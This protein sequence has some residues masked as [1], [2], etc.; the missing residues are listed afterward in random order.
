MIPPVTRRRRSSGH[1][2]QNFHRSESGAIAL[3]MLAG[4][5]ILMLLAW[6]I[7]DSGK[8]SREKI[9]AQ[10][11]ADMAVS[12]QAAI[13]A[14]AINMMAY[15][16]VAKRSIFAIHTTY[17]SNFIAY[18]KWAGILYSVGDYLINWGV[19]EIGT[20][21][22]SAGDKWIHWWKDESRGDFKAFS[23]IDIAQAES[24]SSSEDFLITVGN[25]LQNIGNPNWATELGSTVTVSTLAAHAFPV[26]SSD[27]SGYSLRYHAQDIRAL[28]NYQRYLAGV[29]PWWGWS[30]QL[31]RGMRNGASATGTFPLPQDFDQ[32]LGSTLNQLLPGDA[33]GTGVIDTLPIRPADAA[34]FDGANT[35]NQPRMSMA[36]VIKEQLKSAD[37][38]DM[39]GDLIDGGTPDFENMSDSVM[40]VEHLVNILGAVLSSD[41]PELSYR[42]DD[43][44]GD[45]DSGITLDAAIKAVANA[46]V[47]KLV[48]MVFPLVVGVSTHRI[49]VDQGLGFTQKLF[50]QA[51][52]SA[53]ASPWVVLRYPNEA[54]WLLKTSNIVLSYDSRHALFG[55]ERK[56]HNIPSSEY[57]IG[58]PVSG[59]GGLLGSLGKSVYRSSGYWGIARA[60]VYFSADGEPNL[61]NPVWNSRLRPV[62]LDQEFAQ[63]DYTLAGVY[64]D[65]MV[66][67]MMIGALNISDFDPADT[68]GDF[69][70]MG[71]NMRALGPSTSGGLS[72]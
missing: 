72:K 71:R 40:L 12:S 51:L 38:F 9:D 37:I 53:T 23:N 36:D 39:L 28:D 15:S 8:A 41:Y 66:S 7:F 47:S 69:V 59:A 48:S 49:Y 17:I 10:A 16:N 63:A 14:R 11:A 22:K 50:D 20:E 31:V 1:A 55:A 33:S 24:L 54:Q 6:T 62:S 60:E 65:I 4:A 2:L 18:I 67:M 27:W 25:A 3:L 64:R 34:I 68:L 45:S 32:G 30:E 56:K 42:A 44:L 57:N 52:G 43:A 21:F 58:E 61:W 5:L 19:E 29:T 13:K 35:D 46:A 26:S 70:Q